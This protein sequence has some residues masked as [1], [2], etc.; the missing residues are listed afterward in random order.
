M[1]QTSGTVELPIFGGCQ[2]GAV[3]YRLTAPPLWVSTCHCTNCQKI[4]GSAFAVNAT[5]REDAFAIDKGAPKTAEWTA[6]S[7]N[8]RFGLFCAACSSR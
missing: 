7:G 8:R 5:V 3:R 2:C 1:K 4:S 6:D